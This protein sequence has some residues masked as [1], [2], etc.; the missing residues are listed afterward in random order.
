M[1]YGF[2]FA[3]EKRSVTDV[4]ILLRLKKLEIG[5]RANGVDKKA[6]T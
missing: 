3:G 4:S 2:F 5:D 1:A 6:T